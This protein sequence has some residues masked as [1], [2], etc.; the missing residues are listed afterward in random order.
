MNGTYD[1]EAWAERTTLGRRV[2]NAGFTLDAIDHAGW[3]LIKS[4][5]MEARG[6][7]EVAYIL[8][9]GDDLKRELVR[10]DIAETDAWRDAHGRLAGELDSSMR[11]NVPEGTGALAT[12]GDVNFTV[13]EPASDLPVAISFTRGNLFVRLASV[14]DQSVAVDGLARQI[15]GA[16]SQPPQR[17]DVTRRGTAVQPV[18]ITARGKGGRRIVFRSLTGAVPAGTWLKVIAP[19]GELR[20]EGRALAIIVDGPGTRTIQSFATPASPSPPP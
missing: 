11:A 5:P 7:R 18:E 10:V 1:T 20:R 9:R 19:D 17:R 6:E 15:D 16:L 14:G 3:R 4:V 12:T 13:R 2:F 8:Q